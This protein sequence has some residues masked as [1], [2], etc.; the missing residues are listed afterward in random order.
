MS[1]FREAESTFSHYDFV[2]SDDFES[3]QIYPHLKLPFGLTFRV[4]TAAVSFTMTLQHPAAGACPPRANS[5]TAEVVRCAKWRRDSR[6]L[7][8]IPGL[9]KALGDFV[10]YAYEIVDN[11]R[12]PIEPYFSAY[13]K[14]ADAN[15]RPD[16]LVAAAEGF[17]TSRSLDGA[18]GLQGGTSFVG[19]GAAAESSTWSASAQL[20]WRWIRDGATEDW[21]WEHVGWGHGGSGGGRPA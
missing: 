2:F 1:F 16:A 4:P 9:S 5:S 10:Y 19:D 21:W 12:Q 13:L 11:E 18:D 17:D 20:A 8:L 14:W 6:V 7:Q 15:S 3:C